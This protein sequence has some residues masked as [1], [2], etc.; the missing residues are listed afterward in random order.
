[1]EDAFGLQIRADVGETGIRTREKEV[2]REARWMPR[3][4]EGVDHAFVARRGRS[5]FAR[6]N[7]CRYTTACDVG[8]PKGEEA[9]KEKV[10]YF[11]GPEGG[12]NRG[13]GEGIANERGA[14]DE[15]SGV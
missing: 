12:R 14:S 8:K 7:F 9:S 10:F 11:A 2:G 13:D 5:N 1:M 6:E 4:R 15:M 3:G